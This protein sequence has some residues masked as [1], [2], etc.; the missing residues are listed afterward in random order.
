MHHKSSES[1]ASQIFQ[2][3][4]LEEALFE[5]GKDCR[6]VAPPKSWSST[7]HCNATAKSS[8]KIIINDKCNVDE[9]ANRALQSV[10]NDKS[11]ANLEVIRASIDGYP[12]G[13]KHGKAI[14][15]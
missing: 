2:L 3:Q 8:S 1:K 13:K 9:I 12:G 11:D 6:N 14:S 4:L 7:I 5:A 15:N 10:M